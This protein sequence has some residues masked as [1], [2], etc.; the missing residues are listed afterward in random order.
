[1]NRVINIV[2]ICLCGVVRNSYAQTSLQELIDKMSDSDRK[3]YFENA[4]HYIE[5]TYYNQLFATL[6][7]YGTYAYVVEDLMA[8]DVVQCKPEILWKGGECRF[9]SPMEYLYCL[10]RE[11]RELNADELEFTVSNIIFSPEILPHSVSGFCVWADYDLEVHYQSRTLLT[12]RCRMYCLFPK[13]FVKTRIRLLQV[14]PLGDFADGQSAFSISS[15]EKRYNEAMH[16]YVQKQEEK[17]LPVFRELAEKGY[18]EAE[19]RY[20]ICLRNKKMFEEA[21]LWFEKAAI[22]GHAKAQNLFGC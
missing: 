7:D 19:Y 13:Y 2:I 20:G 16:W 3:E 22:K 8:E 18:T 9:L 6:F 4:K 10:N 21:V 14:E 12:H 17:Y 15:D 5:T 1:M 11:Y